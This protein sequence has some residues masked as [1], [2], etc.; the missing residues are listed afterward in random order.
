MSKKQQFLQRKYEH[1]LKKKQTLTCLDLADIQTFQKTLLYPLIPDQDALVIFQTL[2]D[3]LQIDSNNMHAQMKILKDWKAKCE[4]ETTSI[5]NAVLLPSTLMLVYWFQFQNNHQFKKIL[6]S[7]I[8]VCHPAGVK[9]FHQ[10][11]I[12]HQIGHYVMDRTILSLVD[13]D[14]MIKCLQALSDMNAIVDVLLLLPQSRDR[15]FQCMD[16]ILEHIEPLIPQF[17]HSEACG[18]LLQSILKITAIDRQACSDDQTLNRKPRETNTDIVQAV[19]RFS[20]AILNTHHVSKDIYTQAGLAICT[21]LYYSM[22]QGSCAPKVLESVLVMLQP[23]SVLEPIPKLALVRGILGS[24][25]DRDLINGAWSQDGCVGMQ[26][27]LDHIL[28][29]CVHSNQHVRLYALQ[30]LFSWLKRGIQLAK[31]PHPSASSMR[32]IIQSSKWTTM[33]RLLLLEFSN[34]TKRVNQFLMPLFTTAVDFYLA[35]LTQDSSSSVWILDLVTQIQGLVTTAR[36]KWNAFFVILSKFSHEDHHLESFLAACPDLVPQLFDSIQHDACPTAAANVF[37]TCLPSLQPRSKWM[38]RVAESLLGSHPEPIMTYCIPGLM[39][40][41]PEVAMELMEVLRNTTDNSTSGEAEEAFLR[42]GLEILKSVQKV[43]S[44]AYLRTLAKPGSEQRNILTR[45][46]KIQALVHPDRGLRD[47]AFETLCFHP[48][49]TQVP[50]QDEIEL[51]KMFLLYAMPLSTGTSNRFSTG[52]TSFCQR[53]AKSRSSSSSS[54]DFI[55]WLEIFVLQNLFPGASYR[56]LQCTFQIL[57]VMIAQFGLPTKIRTIDLV[58]CLMHWLMSHWDSVRSQAFGVLKCCGV[59]FQPEELHTFMNHWFASGLAL[60]QSPKIRESEAGGFILRCCIHYTTLVHVD[61]CL[62]SFLC[63]NFPDFHCPSPEATEAEGEY[64]SMLYF[65]FFCHALQHQ[66]QCLDDVNNQ[67]HAIP[68]FHGTLQ[69]LQHLLLETSTTFCSNSG[70]AQLQKTQQKW[71]HSIMPLLEHCHRIVEYA[72]DHI[73]EGGDCRG[74]AFRPSDAA[75]DLDREDLDHDHDQQRVMSCWLGLRGAGFVAETLLQ[76][77]T[78]VP[79]LTNSPTATIPLLPEEVHELGL[80]LLNALLV[81]KHKGAVAMLATALEGMCRC[82]FQQPVLGLEL[83]QLWTDELLLCRLRQNQ[84]SF[85]L[86]RSGGFAATFLAI[87]RAEMSTSGHASTAPFLSQIMSELQSLASTTTTASESGVLVKSRIHALNILKLVYQDASLTNRLEVYIPENFVLA[88]RGLVSSDWAIRNSSMMLFAALVQRAIGCKSIADGGFYTSGISSCGFW[89]RFPTLVDI[90]L[91]HWQDKNENHPMSWYPILMILVRLRGHHEHQ[92]QHPPPLAKMLARIQIQGLGHTNGMIRVMAAQAMTTMM[93]F[94]K[95]FDLVKELVSHTCAFATCLA[96]LGHN[97]VHGLLVFGLTFLEFHQA[98][99]HDEI[100]SFVHHSG[101][102]WSQ[103]F[104]WI[105][106]QPCLILR[107]VALEL[108]SFFRTH[109]ILNCVTIQELYVQLLRPTFNQAVVQ[110]PTPRSSPIPGEALYH[111]KLVHLCLD[112]EVTTSVFPL[113]VQLLTCSQ[114]DMRQTSIEWWNQQW[115]KCNTNTNK[116]NPAEFEKENKPRDDLVLALLH[117]MSSETHGPTRRMAIVILRQCCQSSS[118]INKRWMVEIQTQVCRMVNETLMCTNAGGRAELIQLLG[119]VLG[120]STLLECPHLDMLYH[121]LE[122]D[123]QS[124]E[125]VDCR[126]AA[127]H[128]LG[129]SNALNCQQSRFWWIALTL[130]QDDEEDI[131]A[132]MGT[133]VAA[134]LYHHRQTEKIHKTHHVLVLHQ[135]VRTMVETFGPTCLDFQSTCRSCL[136]PSGTGHTSVLTRSVVF[137]EERDNYYLEPMVLS[138]LLIDALIDAPALVQHQCCPDLESI[139]SQ[140]QDVL[141]GGKDIVFDDPEMFH[142]VYRTLCL[143]Q[144]V[145][146]FKTRSRAVQKSERVTFQHPVLQSLWSRRKEARQLLFLTST[147]ILMRK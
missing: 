40:Q 83:L 99:H 80:K 54:Q 56:R 24:V 122:R 117:M 85:V 141:A 114:L 146:H 87:L 17:I 145:E 28:A 2:I 115:A 136:S 128:C 27:I 92:S 6:L 16:H 132:Q 1:V 75:S 123:C 23:E 93:P 10:G 82:L 64:G 121:V 26:F 139:E 7:M 76:V 125:S 101:F 72:M 32:M 74:H 90:L 96:E 37:L 67:E 14:R 109:D 59:V 55:S 102:A 51:M 89:T 95:A 20:F 113:L 112:V 12:E 98:D 36:A 29:D 3:E 42:A 71:R 5:W 31:L 104:Q 86:R 47:V 120:K 107:V 66:V 119:V 15:L 143:L 73:G 65:Q 11:E 137:D 50:S 49:M 62:E 4:H 9:A 91:K 30:V 133:Y 19:L 131:R 118:I 105:L 48:K 126:H 21:F 97:Q 108:L 22:P 13:V 38:K 53:I 77:G 84:Q 61:F 70:L 147:E 88:F 110:S 35:N 100:V 43:G 103:M 116:F 58:Q 106:T 45:E 94:S 130:L 69:I 111:Q 60:I 129:Q 41:Y 52:F 18:H 79:D 44:K 68:M 142:T 138:Q 63:Q 127:M 124:Q 46:E 140:L 81:V 57:P 135:A 78:L 33:I 144:M 34:P 8:D 25:S 39:K 134:V